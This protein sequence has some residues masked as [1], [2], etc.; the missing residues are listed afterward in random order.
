MKKSELLKA[1]Q[2]EILR[3]DFDCF[4]D[5]PPSVAQGGR[6]VVVP[7]CPACK[8]RIQTMNQFLDHLAEDAMPELIEKLSEAK[9]G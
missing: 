2:K 1:L 8:K 4:V 6:A 7:G 3:H 5:E 9:T